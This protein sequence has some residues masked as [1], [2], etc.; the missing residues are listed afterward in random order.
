MDARDL[1]RVVVIGTSCSGKTTFAKGLARVLNRHHIEL[2]AINWLPGW[3]ERPPEEFRRLVEEATA[4]D[5][6]VVDGNYSRVREVV[7]SRATALIW[8]DYSFHVVIWRALSRTLRRSISREILFSG[9]RESLRMT[10]LSR[11]SILLWILKTYRR[12]RREYSKMLQETDDVKVGVLT[13][14]EDASRFLAEVR[15]Q[16]IN[17]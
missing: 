14:P 3:T 15:S 5:E 16:L 12:R 11:D 17:R 1:N 13:S 7:W 9:N 6:W 4:Q 10:F 2:D 8:L